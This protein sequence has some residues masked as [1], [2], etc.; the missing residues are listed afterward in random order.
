[1]S[2]RRSEAFALDFLGQ[3]AAARGEPQAAT[4]FRRSLSIYETNGDMM[5]IGIVNYHQGFAALGRGD[6]DDAA[7]LNAKAMDT[8]RD[9]GYI[10]GENWAQ[11]NL[12]VAESGMGREASAVKLHLDCVRS[13]H[14]FGFRYELLNGLDRLAELIADRDPELALRCLAYAAT[15]REQSGYAVLLS[16]RNAYEAC[17]DRLRGRLTTDAFTSNWNLGIAGA[18]DELIASLTAIIGSEP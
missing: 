7:E 1:L 9:Y 17:L 16:D 3:L 4:H 18:E 10:R 15:G 2:K 8:W 13:A 11:Y 14:R 6:Y 12:A 5:G